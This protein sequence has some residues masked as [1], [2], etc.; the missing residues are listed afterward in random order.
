MFAKICQ[1]EDEGKAFNH[2]TTLTKIL[3][4]R[5]RLQEIHLIDD[6]S[7]TPHL[8]LLKLSKDPQLRR[9][10]GLICTLSCSSYL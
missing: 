3:R 10:V 4:E 5:C 9:K 6:D 7:F 8:T 2:L 1:E